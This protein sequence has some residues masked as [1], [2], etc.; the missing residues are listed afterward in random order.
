MTSVNLPGSRVAVAP[1]SLTNTHP[2]LPY[3]TSLS[4]SVN[5]TKPN[6]T[7]R[8]L[9]PSNL[10]RAPISSGEIIRQPVNVGEIK[11]RNNP[12]ESDPMVMPGDFPAEFIQ[13]QYVRDI[14]P[15]RSD[16]LSMRNVI[17]NPETK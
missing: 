9:P 8:I 17:N 16:R 13:S 7:Q 10:V 11:P 4:N 5:H 15:L 3:T 6:S 2:P 14:N 1:L 12:S